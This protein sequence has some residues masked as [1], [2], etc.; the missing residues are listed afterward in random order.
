MRAVAATGFRAPNV[1]ELYGGNSGSFDYLD[2]PWGNEV[3]PQILVNYTSDENLKP[4]ESESLTFGMVWEIQQGLSTTLDYWKFD[5]TDAI[6]RVNVQSAMNA[7]YAGNM[8]ACDTINITPDGDLSE[9]SSPL[10]NVGSLE[11]SGVDWNITFSGDMFKVT[12]DTTY[13]IDYTEDGIDYTGTIDGNMGGYA[14]LKSNLNVSANITDD[15]SVLYTAQY[16]QG[17]D[18]DYY[19][20]A[21]STDSVVYH[22]ISAAYHI[23]DQWKVNGGVKNLFDTEPES[24]PDGNDMGTVPAIYDVV[25]RTFFVSTS[26]KF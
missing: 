17:M 5:V 10:T 7:C 8:V 16:I 9:L 13:L 15:F 25:G 19:G 21:Y 3:D 22:N 6:T 2:D 4:E 14:E 18:G 20:E 12:L 26:Y 23:N 24:V 11:T 1:A